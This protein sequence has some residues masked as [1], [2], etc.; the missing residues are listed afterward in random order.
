[1]KGFLAALN[2]LLHPSAYRQHWRWV[3]WGFNVSPS[4]RAH[5]GGGGKLASKF[6]VIFWCVLLA[7]GVLFTLVEVFE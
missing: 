6:E 5:A 3:S 2:R 7:T 4:F 1:M